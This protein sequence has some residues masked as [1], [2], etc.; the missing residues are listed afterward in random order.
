[1]V[2]IQRTPKPDK[3]LSDVTEY[4]VTSNKSKVGV[5]VI[6]GLTYWEKLGKW[7]ILQ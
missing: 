2:L 6:K 1:M 3:E 4:K 7:D 5:P